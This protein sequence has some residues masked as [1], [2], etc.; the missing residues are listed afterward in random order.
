MNVA[1]INTLWSSLIV[2]ELIRNEINYFCI[3]PGSRS[4]PLT[5]AVAENPRAKH[6]ICFDERGAAFH[7]LGYGRATGKP[8]ALI[9]TSGTAA[10]NYFPAVIE[11]SVDNI[12][13]IILTADRPP[14]LRKTGANQT[15]D[16]VS[17]YGKYV[18]WEFDLPCPD[19][20]IFPQMVL[21]TIDQAVFRSRRN[22]GGP[23]HINC[24]FREPLA[25]VVQPVKTDYIQ[26]LSAWE[27]EN[28][29][30][31][32]YQ[33]SL[34]TPHTSDLQEIAN[35]INNAKRGIIVAGRLSSTAQS[36]SILELAQKINFPVF[37]DIN[38]GLRFQLSK[39]NFISHYDQ[40][41]VIE[42][43][44][45][46]FAPDTILQFGGRITS[47]RLLKF[48]DRAKP[49]NYIQVL[50]GPQRHDPEHNVTHHI[51]A[52]IEAFCRLMLRMVTANPGTPW[53]TSF[54]ESSNIIESLLDA[55]VNPEHAISEVSAARIVS[56]LIPE[57][58]ALFLGS[59]MPVRDM[60]MFASANG[61]IIPVAANRGASGIDG[62]LASATGFAAAHNL[63]VTLILGDLAMI[64]DLNS[65]ALLRSIKQQ[66]IIIITN[67]NGS[68]I[69]SFLPIAEFDDIFENF[70]GT[71]H[72]LTFQRAAE[73]FEIDYHHPQTNK[74]FRKTYQEV[75]MNGQP[76][77][78]EI[79]TDR[80]ENF[81]LHKK[82]ADRIRIAFQS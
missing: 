42:E 18:N 67:N 70:F 6:I 3:S 30:F 66:L 81:E 60:D 28:S 55:Y 43:L 61:T 38:S 54:V 73:M 25:P 75:L 34:Q 52:N 29:P 22:T 27:K 65:L 26:P 37:P 2:E 16:Q 5:V 49:K 59:S 82:I 19:E 12:P 48:I 62:T 4:A 63:P 44:W 64:H 1:N 56:Q 35:I 51:E 36:K 13:M 9:C 45:Q 80:R 46:K 7:A 8:A 14:E 39:N 41:L 74:D 68:G 32:K 10:A 20:T 78:I 23:V 72:D 50:E 57:K 69:F 33:L 53:L 58:S 31:T 47:K 17:L 11:A 40:I 24:M 77:M 79:H 21:T 15:I 76:A 71:P